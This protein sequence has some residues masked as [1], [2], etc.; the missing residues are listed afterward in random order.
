M[1]HGLQLGDPERPG[2]EFPARVEFCRLPPEHEVRLLENVVGVGRVPDKRKNVGVQLPL[3]ISDHADWDELR[4]TVEETGCSE[5][6]VTHGAEDALVH[7]AAQRGLQARPLN[8][9]GY[10][11]DGEPAAEAQP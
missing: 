1:C 3:G 2:N 8:L 9:I 10:G 4:A 5:L 6:W 11:D 7:W